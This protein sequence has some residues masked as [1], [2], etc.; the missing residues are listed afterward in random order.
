MHVTLT[1]EDVN[2][3]RDHKLF[4]A[5]AFG[6]GGITDGLPYPPRGLPADHSGEVMDQFYVEA[7]A[8]RD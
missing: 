6:D 7:D 2:I 1:F 3:A 4:S 8:L 5:I